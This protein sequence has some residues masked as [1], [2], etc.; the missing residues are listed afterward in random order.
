MSESTRVGRR[1]RSTEATQQAVLD[2]ATDVF[3]RVGYA[4][5]LIGEIVELSSVSVGSIYHHFGG[6]AEIFEALWQRYTDALWQA[7]RA[8]SAAARA[9]GEQDPIELVI[10][11]ARAYLGALSVP[12]VAALSRIIV[13]GDLPPDFSARMRQEQDRWI[14]SNLPVFGS[15][16]NL[17]A[18]LRAAV[19]VAV[20]GEAESLYAHGRDE[21]SLDV[22]IESTAGMLRRLLAP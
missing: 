18:R 15:G 20:L 19:L 6:K 10:A 16:D 5:T 17:D 14:R 1:W 13:S 22:V 9:A 8:G 21:S 3:S 12:A 7:V 11:G 4:E 2:A